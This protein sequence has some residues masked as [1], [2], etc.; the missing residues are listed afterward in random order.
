MILALDVPFQLRSVEVHVPE[1][2]GGIAGSL[3]AEMARLGI[4]TLSAGRDSFRSDR[5]AEF[6]GRDKAV[7]GRPV[8]LLRAGIRSR[9]E[10]CQRSPLRRCERYRNARSRIIET[11]N[12][13]ASEPL[14]AINIPPWRFPRPE[15]GRELIEQP[16]KAPAVAVRWSWLW[17]LSSAA[18]V[19]LPNRPPAMSESTAPT[20]ACST[21]PG[22]LQVQPISPLT[23]GWKLFQP[24][25]SPAQEFDLE[26]PASNCRTRRR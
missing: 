17:S 8:T 23:D 26:M 13:I 19:L 18:R 10:R 11:L 16:R 9:S 21:R 24:R 25:L 14:I 6:D 7:A 4:A 1:V 12:N 15:I 3:I 5:R 2:T 20:T 22:L